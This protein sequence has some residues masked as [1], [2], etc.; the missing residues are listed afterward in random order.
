V[1]LATQ[2]LV[3]PMVL[4]PLSALA[5]APLV[6][7]PALSLAAVRALVLAPVQS[8]AQMV[9]EGLDRVEVL[10]EQ[11][12]VQASVFALLL[13]LSQPQHPDQSRA[14]RRGW[15]VVLARSPPLVEVV[16]LAEAWVRDPS[17]TPLPGRF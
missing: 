13:G 10:P 2:V 1:T 16:A 3:L 9:V 14:S 17:T 11:P 4:V 8:P 15:I 7:V 12:W 5:L 6:Q